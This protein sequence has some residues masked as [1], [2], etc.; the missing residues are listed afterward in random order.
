MHVLASKHGLL[1]V[2]HITDFQLGTRGC[3]D[4]EIAVEV[5]YSGVRRSLLHNRGT[6]HGFTVGINDSAREG[7]ILCKCHY[8]QHDR[9]QQ[10]KKSF[11]F[12]VTLLIG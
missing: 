12:H 1:A 2:A 9:Q 6:N 7:L 11:L 3:V 8:G 10:R 4:G 5:R